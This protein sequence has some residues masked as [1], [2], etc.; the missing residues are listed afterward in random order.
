MTT[1]VRS[2]V[3]FLYALALVA[4]GAPMPDVEVESAKQKHCYSNADCGALDFCDTEASGQCGG[5]G[6]C[7]PR[8]VNLFCSSLYVGVCGCDGQSYANTCYLHK[9]GVSLA[10]D[11]ACKPTCFDDGD[12][13][14]TEYCKSAPGECGGPGSCESRGIGLF[15]TQ[16][17]QPVCGCDGQTWANAC[18]AQKAG[19]AVDHDGAC[20][21]P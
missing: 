13:G 19:A 20:N 9:A 4:C 3:V 17:W 8:G 7:Q 18:H 16:L 14:P 21:Q 12:C 5:R 2:L 11:G 10:H 15:C 1:L 6:T